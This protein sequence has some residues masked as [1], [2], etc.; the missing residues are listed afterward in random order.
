MAVTVGAQILGQEI[1]S[2]ATYCYMYEPLRIFM[3]EDDNTAQKFY[4]DMEILDV[5]DNTVVVESLF[6][7]GEFDINPGNG[8]SVDLMKLVRQY[9]DAGVY[10][11]SHIDEI[12]DPTAGWYSSVSKYVYNFLVYSDINQTPISI[13][14]IPIIGGRIY[15][16]F[17]AQVSQFQSLTEAQLY[18]VDLANRWVGYP[19]ISASLSDP[20]LQD[21]SPSLIKNISVEGV[22]PCGGYLIWKSIFG[23]W[24]SWGFDIKTKKLKKKYGGDLSSGMFEPT[25]DIGGQPY[26][27]PN[28]T[29]IESSYSLSMKSLGLSSEELSAVSGIELSPA[30]Y[31]M[32][33]SSGSLELMRLTSSSAPL[34]TL[35]NGGDFSVSLDS[36][37]TMEQLTR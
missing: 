32:K 21:S 22:V 5:S 11:Y 12:V 34:S 16:D 37:S 4:I 6:R 35:S 13:K 10:N 7:Y 18:G 1:G 14:K 30:V 23:G 29:K 20:S 19:T 9:H 27:A 26:I 17:T 15:E 33:D 2:V 28:Y 36:I 3:A 8:V 24:M 31:Y 25:Q